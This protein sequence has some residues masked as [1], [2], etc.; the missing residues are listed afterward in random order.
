MTEVVIA[1]GARTP[2]G[3]FNGSLSS[4]PAHYL[5]EVAIKAALERAGVDPKDVTETIMV[6]TNSRLPIFLPSRRWAAWADL[7]MLSWPPETT[8]WLSPFKIA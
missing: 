1:S 6:S 2:V 4:V 8:I 3:S 5:G 7:D